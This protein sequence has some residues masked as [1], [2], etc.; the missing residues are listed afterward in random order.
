VLHEFLTANR[1]E[2]AERCR[3]KVAKRSSPPP[4]GT[5]LEH[6][7]PVLIDQL[8]ESLRAMRLG[9]QIT[10]SDGGPENIQRSATL[11]G[12][13][14]LRRGFTVD[15]VVHDYGDLCQA[16]TELAAE[17]KEPITVPEFHE[18]NRC[19]DAAIANAVTEFG[20]Q[21]D[22][23]KS[24]AAAATLNE[25][26]G[27]LAHELRN[28][29]NTST[30]AFTAIRSGHG[31]ITGATGSVLERSL[32][33]LRGLLDRELAATRLTSGLHALI[34]LTSVDEIL[35]EAR[36]AA[37][38]DAAARRIAFSVSIEPDLSVTADRQMLSSAL[39]NLLQN[40][41]KFTQP[42]GHVTMTA[43]V[44]DKNVRIEVADGCGGLAPGMT[45]ELFKPFVQRNADR[46]G[47]G[48]G[49]SISRRAVEANG[50]TLSVR[51]RPGTGCIFTIELPRS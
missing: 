28:L 40:A 24:V 22:D 39:A 46:S 48:L 25:R 8:V 5:E 7:I 4:S 50:G 37:Q 6:G 44:V 19:L 41:F 51:D 31:A 18:F 14:L 38:L 35:E 42:G 16:V 36:V 29:L 17:T 21:R 10:R 49:L 3:A 30:L 33:D 2:L 43:H 13:Q 34:V 9:G 23:V 45:D 20:R 11:H 1:L 47:V 27:S 26:L 15:Q 32:Q 12:G